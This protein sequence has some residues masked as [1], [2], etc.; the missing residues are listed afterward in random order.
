MPDEIEDR[1]RGLR[2]RQHA[3]EILARTQRV[4]AAEL[5]VSS[6]EVPDA[7]GDVAGRTLSNAG[8]GVEPAEADE[9]QR[10]VHGVR[11][12]R[13]DAASRLDRQRTLS[14]H[15]GGEDEHLQVVRGI[16]RNPSPLA[17]F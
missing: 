2:G 15:G 7:A 12:Q 3:I 4:A 6:G 16:G 17:A 13:R 8:H 11:R 9:R 14:V 5:R 1:F 10:V